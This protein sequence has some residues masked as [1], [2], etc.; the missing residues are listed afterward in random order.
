[1]KKSQK[2]SEGL[3]TKGQVTFS[4]KRKRRD[5]STVDVSLSGGP[6]AVNGKI[7]GFFMAYVDISNLIIVQ[8]VLANAL[9][10]A[11]LLNEKIV[12]LGG[13]TRHDVRNKLGLISG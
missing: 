5:G 10:K 2:L 8:N 1:M 4:T 12:V 11:E 9:S 6:L 3:I 7:V 13:F